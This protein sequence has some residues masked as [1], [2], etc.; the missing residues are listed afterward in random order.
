[1]I[2]L[3][4]SHKLTNYE[5]IANDNCHSFSGIVA[6]ECKGDLWVDDLDNPRISIVYSYPVGSFTFLGSIINV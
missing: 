4:R 2:K 1:M 6:G 3:D 5:N